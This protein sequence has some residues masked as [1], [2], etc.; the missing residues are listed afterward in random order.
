[1]LSDGKM[2]QNKSYQTLNA[3]PSSQSNVESNTD[4]VQQNVGKTGGGNVTLSTSMN[5]PSQQSN[6][7]LAQ[8]RASTQQHCYRSG[9]PSP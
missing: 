6:G 5:M 9:N 2:N 1:M 8:H 4:K 3:M 7:E